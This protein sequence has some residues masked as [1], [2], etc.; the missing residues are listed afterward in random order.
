MCNKRPVAPLNSHTKMVYNGDVSLN[1]DTSPLI[2]PNCNYSFK[3][4]Q[5]VIVNITPLIVVAC[6]YKVH[7]LYKVYNVDM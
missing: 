6:V 5:S 4:E 1:S 2:T 7:C 3:Y